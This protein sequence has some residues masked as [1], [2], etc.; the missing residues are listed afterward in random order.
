MALG[1]QHD[2]STALHSVL[3]WRFERRHPANA[4][5]N[6]N[7]GADGTLCRDPRQR[8]LKQPR[9]S[10]AVRAA[11][12]RLRGRPHH[13]MTMGTAQHDA[14]TLPNEPAHSFA[15]SSL[16]KTTP[17][18]RTA[19][20]RCLFD[21]SVSKEIVTR[22]GAKASFKLLHGSENRIAFSGSTTSNW[23]NSPTGLMQTS[24]S[25]SVLLGRKAV[26]RRRSQ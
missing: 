23:N 20:L 15:K 16:S 14:I 3:L 19:I 1:N 26:D 4:G 18:L 11:Q 6:M 12:Q 25:R 2:C 8:T 7:Y 24:G 13:R 5:R 17:R 9:G 10:Q 22:E 21:S